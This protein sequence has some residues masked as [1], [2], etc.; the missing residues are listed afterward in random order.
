MN[1]PDKFYSLEGVEDLEKLEKI[2]DPEKLEGMDDPEKLGSLEYLE[3]WRTGRIQ[4]N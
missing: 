1:E 2:E 4:R 3:Y